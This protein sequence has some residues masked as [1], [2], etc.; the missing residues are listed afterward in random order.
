L[1][2]WMLLSLLEHALPPRFT[3][4]WIIFLFAY[5]ITLVWFTV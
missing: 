5:G 3:D 1:Q 4:V 2:V